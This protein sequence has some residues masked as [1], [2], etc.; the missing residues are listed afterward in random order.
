MTTTYDQTFFDDQRLQGQ[1]SA[2]EIVPI[3]L[4]MVQPRSVV[5]VGCGVGA[6]LSV[7]KEHGIADV[8]GVDGGWASKHGQLP[9][10]EFVERDLARP[11]SLDRTFDLVVSLEV[12]EHLPPASAADF[13]KSLV[14]L[15]PTVLFSAAAP[16]QGGTHHLNEQWPDYWASLFDNHGYHAVDCLRPLIW[17]N[18]SVEWYYAQNSFLFVSKENV[19]AIRMPRN[20]GVR[21]AAPLPLVH[22]SNYLEKA[23]RANIGLADVI[24]MIPSLTRD[25]VMRRVQRFTR[26][27]TPAP[28]KPSV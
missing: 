7:F 25:A 20:G 5:D 23:R 10:N 15:G 27:N 11:L 24:K 2:R 22:P 12:A 28:S 19:G 18:R 3:V 8:L 14:G 1:R 13:I 6:W 26:R 21:G 4:E 9:P 17:N 16:L